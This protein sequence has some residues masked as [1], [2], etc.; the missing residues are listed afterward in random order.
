MNKDINTWL[1]V[2]GLF[3]KVHLVIAKKITRQHKE[4]ESIKTIITTTTGRCKAR[5][6]SKMEWELCGMLWQRMCVVSS[7][8]GLDDARAWLHTRGV[9][10]F[11]HRSPWSCYIQLSPDF[12]TGC[13]CCVVS[14]WLHY[15]YRVITITKEPDTAKQVKNHVN[16]GGQKVIFQAIARWFHLIC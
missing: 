15:H 12:Y 6:N 8:W 14:A 10:T 4:F 9:I 3:I 7:K 5:P 13:C 11:M 2:G 1:V 16:K